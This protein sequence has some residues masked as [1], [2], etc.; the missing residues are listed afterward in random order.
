MFE[1]CNKVKRSVVAGGWPISHEVISDQLTISWVTEANPS[2]E[3]GS[4]TD[5]DN[6]RFWGV[7]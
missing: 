1:D 7:A 5:Y 4:I 3:Y 2:R 6:R